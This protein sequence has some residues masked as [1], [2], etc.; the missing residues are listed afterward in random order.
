MPDS[1]RALCTDFYVNQKLQVKM[2]LPRTRETILDF[3]ERV[4]K[5]HPHMMGFRK[6]RDELA[7]E[8]NQ[9]DMPHRWLAVK[10][11]TV[12][13]G[14]VN[15]DSL[16]DAYALHQLV[17]E[18]AP[19]YLTVSPLDFDHLEVLY[20]FDM[21]AQGNHDAIVFDALLAGSPLAGMMD[22][23]HASISDFQPTLGVSLGRSKEFE[24]Y[25]EVKTRP[26]GMRTR[27]PELGEPI[28]VY[29]TMRKLGPIADMKELGTAFTRLTK[30]GEDLIEHRIV[31]N[32]LVPIHEAIGSG[33]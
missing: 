4:R 13:S 10:G 3:Y 1:F 6:I 24:V 28:S 5:S 2:E 25:V 29:L 27:D 17:I 32:L 9:Q 7:L 18:A 22:I 8:S 23:P 26:A 14:C 11:T 12:R 16:T 31:P 30:M 19:T 15:A 21:I 33:R 20:G